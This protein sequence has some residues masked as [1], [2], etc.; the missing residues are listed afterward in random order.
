MFLLRVRR[1]NKTKK[2]PE[3]KTDS[4]LT[5]FLHQCLVYT[6]EVKA[7]QRKR[8]SESYF[9]ENWRAFWWVCVRCWETPRR[10]PNTQDFRANKKHSMSNLKCAFASTQCGRISSRILLEACSTTT[11]TRISRVVC[12]NQQ[13]G[14][15]KV[16]MS[17][18]HSGQNKN[19]NSRWWPP[20]LLYSG[21]G[22]LVP[23]NQRWN[24]GR[25]M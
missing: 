12:L 18:F 15:R 24:W 9:F 1:W 13:I 2:K 20:K 17:D 3:T 5:I 10:R 25:Y 16:R 11:T 14:R 21:G 22:D 4:R 19:E 6:F 23:K 7:F 8:R